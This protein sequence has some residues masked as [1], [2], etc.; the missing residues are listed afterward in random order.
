MFNE[1]E[2]SHM[3]DVK[4]VAQYAMLALVAGIVIAEIIGVILA[5]TRDGRAVL[6]RS[7]FSAGMLTLMV[8]FG[9]LFYVLVD[10]DYF[11]DSFHSLFF[12]EGSWQFFTTDSLIRLYPITFWQ[13][14]AIVIGVL[15]GLSGV[16][17][18]IIAVVWAR[19][20]NREQRSNQPHENSPVQSTT[21]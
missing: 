10:F 11:F 5:R 21:G 16:I 9:L 8:I 2:L 4:I 18:M 1:R 12:A 6:R 20:E 3:I 7:M 14:S 13:D 19:W 15:W 17:S